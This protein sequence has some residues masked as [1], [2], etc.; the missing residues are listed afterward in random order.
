MCDTSYFLNGRV[1]MC[2]VCSVVLWILRFFA[3]LYEPALEVTVLVGLS[4]NEGSDELGKMR[5]L[6]R[7]T[8]KG[9]GEVRLTLGKEYGIATETHI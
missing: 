8:P 6:A 7:V 4:C 9:Q 5:L 3:I 2:H 1:R